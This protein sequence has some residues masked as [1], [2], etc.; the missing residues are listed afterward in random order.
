MC[1]VLKVFLY[2][3]VVVLRAKPQ[4]P[5]LQGQK[6]SS[7]KIESTQRSELLSLCLSSLPT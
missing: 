1:S 6:T 7:R 4:K 5:V 3:D 2:G